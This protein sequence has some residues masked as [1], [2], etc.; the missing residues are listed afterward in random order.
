MRPDMY[1]G[2]RNWTHWNVSLWL[3][4]DEGLYTMMRHYVARTD[5]RD[6][7]ARAILADCIATHGPATPDGARWSFTA[8]RAAL[9][10]WES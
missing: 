6:D 4:N 10:G 7:A 9:V 2:H 5:T 8:I 3:F 1:L